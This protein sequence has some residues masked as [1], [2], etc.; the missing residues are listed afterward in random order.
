VTERFIRRLGFFLGIST[1]ILFFAPA[2]SSSA[3]TQPSA[4]RIGYWATAEGEEYRPLLEQTAQYLT[5][6][7]PGCHFELVPLDAERL[8]VLIDQGK[9]D[10]V[11]LDPAL[12][13]QLEERCSIQRLATAQRLYHGK[14]YSMLGGTVFCL[15]SRTDLS[16]LADLMKGTLSTVKGDTLGA[17]LSVLRE[18]QSR[19]FDPVR[20]CKQLVFTDTEAAAVEKVLKGEAD[21]GAVRAGV[22]ERMTEKRLIRLSDFRTLY[23]KGAHTRNGSAGFPFLVSTRL[24]PEWAFAACARTSRELTRQTAAALLTM[25]APSEAGESSPHMSWTIPDSYVSVHDCLKD[26]RRSPYENYGKIALGDVIRQYMYWI[27]GAGVLFILMVMVTSYVARLNRELVLEIENR[28]KAD[29]SLRE[30]VERFQH[31]VSCSM[32]WIWE[33][34]EEGRFTYSSAIVKEMLGYEA[35]EI[36]GKQFYDLFAAS[37]KEKNR[38]KPNVLSARMDRLFR[39]KLKLLTQG[40]RVVIHEISAAP[41]LNTKGK[42]IGYRGV[43]RDVTTQVR[44]VKL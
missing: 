31:V 38:A 10:F 24:Y 35:D 19:R 42:T 36:V 37:E 2:G 16:G 27:L 28:K 44:Y 13:V 14:K 30:S 5:A 23:F 29:L 3:Q 25:S 22:L 8:S 32:D 40:G 18:F 20:T 4:V 21:A 39:E 17:W 15:K 6:A 9:L 11:F 1:L 43:N 7:I 33:A 12:Y 26:L 34:N 41:V